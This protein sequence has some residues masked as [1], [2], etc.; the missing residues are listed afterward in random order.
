MEEQP[1]HVASTDRRNKSI[2]AEGIAIEAVIE[3]VNSQKD[4]DLLIARL[5][6]KKH[7]GAMMSK[8]MGRC[9]AVEA[10]TLLPP[11]EPLDWDNI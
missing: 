3:D 6:A 5:Q 11:E 1:E 8:S 4:I 7:Q 10:A 9:S 2:K